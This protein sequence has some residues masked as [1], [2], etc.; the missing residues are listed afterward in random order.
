[1]KKVIFNIVLILLVSLTSI[2]QTPVFPKNLVDEFSKGL[3]S[4]PLET[5]NIFVHDNFQFITGDGKETKKKDMVTFFTHFQETYREVTDFKYVQS[6]KVVTGTGTLEHHWYRKDKPESLSKYKC[7]FNITCVYEN[8]KWQMISAQHTDL[9]DPDEEQ[10]VKTVI[11]AE[12]AAYHNADIEKLRQQWSNSN[13]NEYQSNALKR[14]FGSTYAKGGQL[15]KLMDSLQENV[16]TKREVDIE[17]TDYEARI[18]GNTAWVTYNQKS[19][20]K[21]GKVLEDNRQTRILEKTNQGWKIVYA[22]GADL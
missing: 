4:K 17:K 20:G 9:N 8:G 6:G 15:T 7:R 1:M 10:K 3:L 22:S 14:L 19:I 11:E 16:K 5:I 21:D 18:N 12:T 13:H 2:A